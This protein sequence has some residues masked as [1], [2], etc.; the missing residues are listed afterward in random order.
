MDLFEGT[1]P[2]RDKYVIMR[3]YHV[4]QFVLK[5]LAEASGLTVSE[6]LR[7]AVRELMKNEAGG[8][9]RKPDSASVQG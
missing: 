8:P 6:L 2:G 5:A 3:V 7:K 9:P 1:A 4:E